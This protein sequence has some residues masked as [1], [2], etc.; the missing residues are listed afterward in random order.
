MVNKT[1]DTMVVLWVTW[2]YRLLLLNNINDS[3]QEMLS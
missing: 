3:I 2:I 1:N